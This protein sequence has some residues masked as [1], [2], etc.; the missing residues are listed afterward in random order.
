[1]KIDLL[2]KSYFILGLFFII[3]NSLIANQSQFFADSINFK[4]PG[5]KEMMRDKVYNIALSN[6]IKG[7]NHVEKRSTVPGNLTPGQDLFVGVAKVIDHGISV[8]RADTNELLNDLE[9]KEEV[10]VEAVTDEET[11]QQLNVVSERGRGFVYQIK[12]KTHAG[13]AMLYRLL[14]DDQQ[15]NTEVIYSKQSLQKTLQGSPDFV[16]VVQARI[17]D[18]AK[19]EWES[20]LLTMYKQVSASDFKTNA[21]KETIIELID[22]T[23]NY[24]TIINTLCLNLKSQKDV[25]N[26][27][28]L[29]N[30]ELFTI[31]LDIAELPEYQRFVDLCKAFEEAQKN[32]AW[33]GADDSWTKL[34]DFFAKGDF[35]KKVL[36]PTMAGYGV[37]DLFITTTKTFNIGGENSQYNYVELVS[38]DLG[39]ISGKE[40]LHPNLPN[41]VPVS[42]EFNRTNEIGGISVT[43]MNGSGKSLGI[44]AWL[45]DMLIAQALG[46][47]R[48]N[49][50]RFTPFG[51]MY[52][53]AN[54]TDTEDMSKAQNEIL[55]LGK[56]VARLIKSQNKTKAV[57]VFDEPLTTSN[58]A[59]STKVLL[60]T[61]EYFN[62]ISSATSIW[63]T[64]HR[65]IISMPVLKHWGSKVEKNIDGT[66][67]KTY[68]LKDSPSL[69]SNLYAEMVKV[70]GTEFVDL[71]AK[72]WGKVESS[73]AAQPAGEQ[74]L[75]NVN[76][77]N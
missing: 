22:N 70:L 69:E 6:H 62:K 3:N 19:G 20:K 54:I 26:Q 56:V 50:I 77:V 13:K 63:I 9:D 46:F 36:L 24:C 18:L 47:C 31:S 68:Q 48:G 61:I 57:I 73:S 34:R 30:K 42:F 25:V 17:N 21:K 55:K 41:P 51:I 53:H 2:D 75:N 12:P 1:M 11:F 58:V 28:S 37:I 14:V 67:N 59:D 52:L 74:V 7:T 8:V 10:D 4:K 35:F 45:L 5:Q 23:K 44:K 16:N 39:E 29:I 27:K 64:H 71:Y 66:Y 72:R 43:G 60:S 76:N 65:E 49:G 32:R 15:A 38:K 40:I 33:F